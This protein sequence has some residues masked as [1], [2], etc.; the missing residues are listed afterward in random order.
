M[1]SALRSTSTGPPS[2]LTLSLSFPTSYHPPLLI[3]NQTPPP[4]PLPFLFFSFLPPTPLPL[5]HLLYSLLLPL[6]FAPTTSLPLQ[7]QNPPPPT[8]PTPTPP[9]PPP[10]THP[11]TVLNDL[12]AADSATRYA[13]MHNLSTS[14]GPH[15]ADPKTAASAL[16]HSD[17][18]QG[19]PDPRMV[20]TVLVETRHMSSWSK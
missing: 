9:P 6:T 20:P 16:T 18:R 1:T 15:P 14:W 8:H 7:I 19:R 13:R 17:R 5:P 11:P 2:T 3:H 12:D 10:T 4:T